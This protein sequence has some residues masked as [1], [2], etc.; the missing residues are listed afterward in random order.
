M[1]AAVRQLQATHGGGFGPD[2]AWFY[3][4]TDELLAARKWILQYSLNR[5]KERIAAEKAK[6]DGKPSDAMVDVGQDDPESPQSREKLYTDL[7]V[8]SLAYDELMLIGG[9]RQKFTQNSSE[10]GD[11]RTVSTCSFSPDGTHLSTASWNN[12]IKVWHVD[13][14]QCVKEFRA[15][16]ERIS[17]IS[18]YPHGSPVIEYGRSDEEEAA[19]DTAPRTLDMASCAADSTIKL[20]NVN[21]T[22]PLAT[23]KGH[24]DRV[25]RLAWHPSGKYLGSTSFDMTWMLWDLETGKPLLEQEGHYKYVA[26]HRSVPS[27][28]ALT[29]LTG[30]CTPLHSKPTARW[31]P[32]ADSTRLHACGTCGQASRS[33]TC[34][35]T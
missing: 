17:H 14:L 34:A 16:K 4:G 15:H 35:A 19:Q 2:E 13:T 10:V 31:W 11:E 28:R 7:K 5:A 12:M 25:C 23:L 27:T 20:W 3:E 9:P 26:V 8:T 22:T 32:P 29:S 24:N 21:S 33:G 1:P 6:R 30:P 18:Y